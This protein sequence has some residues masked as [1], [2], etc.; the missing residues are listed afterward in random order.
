MGRTCVPVPP[1]LTVFVRAVF[2]GHLAGA[3]PPSPP[4]NPTLPSR[5]LGEVCRRRRGPFYTA[6][7]KYL[8]LNP[9]LFPAF[10]YIPSWF[11]HVL[12]SRL[13]AA[14]NRR[15]NV[16]AFAQP[17]HLPVLSWML[18]TGHPERSERSV[19]QGA[20]HSLGLYKGFTYMSSQNNNNRV[21]LNW[22]PHQLVRSILLYSLNYGLPYHSPR[23]FRHGHAVYALKMAKNIGTLKAVSPNLI[24]VKY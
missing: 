12:R 11:H 10:D 23:K 6:L 22:M 21:A 15:L 17:P 14:A 16:R 5:I 7:R 19:A 2:T 3:R 8:I 9:R 20:S 13:H 4:P 1:A 24:A 18:F